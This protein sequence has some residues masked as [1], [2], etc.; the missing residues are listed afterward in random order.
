MSFDPNIKIQ[1]NGHRIEITVKTDNVIFFGE[2]KELFGNMLA[3]I[4]WSNYVG[5]FIA[6]PRKFLNREILG[7]ILKNYDVN[8]SVKKVKI[9][10]DAEVIC[11]QPDEYLKFI[12]KIRAVDTLKNGL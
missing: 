3:T 2:D 4:S 9:Y 10:D 12:N 1:V 8:L 11:I 6:V 7:N 5:E